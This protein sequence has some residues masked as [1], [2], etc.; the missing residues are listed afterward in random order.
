MFP[1]EEHENCLRSTYEE[2]NWEAN[3]HGHPRKLSHP[4]ELLFSMP[5]TSLHLFSWENIYYSLGIR[6]SGGLP[7]VKPYISFLW[8]DVGDMTFPLPCPR[9]WCIWRCMSSCRGRKT[10]SSWFVTTFRRVL[11]WRRLGLWDLGFTGRGTVGGSPRVA[12]DCSYLIITG[13]RVAF[14]MS[15]AC[16]LDFTFQFSLSICFEAADETEEKNENDK[17][18]RRRRKREREREE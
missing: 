1:W 13:W 17:E 15:K 18:E 3:F 8:I 2:Q 4:E 10:S 12:G 14:E 11:I 7:L 6:A 9:W 16:N 5:P